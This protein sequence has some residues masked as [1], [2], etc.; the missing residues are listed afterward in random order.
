MKTFVTVSHPSSTAGYL[1]NAPT[2]NIFTP[3]VKALSI[4][5]TSSLTSLGVPYHSTDLGTEEVT[6]PRH[7]LSQFVTSSQQETY[8]AL[9]LCDS[10]QRP[11]QN[12]ARSR[13]GC[14]S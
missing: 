2:S 3:N 10:S 14:P 9:P 7:P 12:P 11:T 4:H 8:R 6:K 5:K 13:K 1:F